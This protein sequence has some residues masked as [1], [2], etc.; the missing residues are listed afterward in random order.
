MIKEGKP[1]YDHLFGEGSFYKRLSEENKIKLKSLLLTGKEKAS[2]VISAEDMSAGYKHLS[3]VMFKPL[4]KAFATNDIR[5]IRDAFKETAGLNISKETASKFAS[6]NKLD[7]G[8]IIK[9]IES[10]RKRI[11]VEK[12]VETIQ[13]VKRKMAKRL[14]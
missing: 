11:K 2:N 13:E 6:D 9:T 4:E 1:L 12:E 3:S 5:K 7:V 8:K 14:L 10:A